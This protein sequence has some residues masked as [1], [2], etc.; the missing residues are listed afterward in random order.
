MA[1]QQ[2]SVRSRRERKSATLS[3]AGATPPGFPRRLSQKG[4]RS[5]GEYA[6]AALRAALR[7]GGWHPGQHL[8]EDDVA[9]WLG[10]S[11]TPV[12]EAVRRLVAEGLLVLGPWNGALVAELGADQIAGLY[13][14]RESLEGTAA[15]SAAEQATK[16]EI[17]RLREIVAREAD[18]LGNPRALVRINDRFH[19]TLYRAAHNRYLLQ[20]L[21]AVVDTLGLLKHST[22]VLPGS[23]VAAHRQ[24][25][26]IVKAIAKRDPGTAEQMARA[27][28]RD[29]LEL[30]LKLM[31]EGKEQ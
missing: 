2:A 6:Y 18:A 24:H 25:T 1:S 20:S 11:R 15:S 13:A 31:R 17:T 22:F 7:T 19:D 14:V 4:F 12:R 26:A 28:V 16:A 30:R 27:H 3:P 29:S 5:R 10:V 23:G 8:R 9:A 21:T